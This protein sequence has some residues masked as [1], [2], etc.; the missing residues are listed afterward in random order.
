MLRLVDNKPDA[1][2]A[3]KSDA[4]VMAEALPHLR[5][6]SH[7]QALGRFGQRA[8]ESLASLAEIS[9]PSPT[10]DAS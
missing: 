3:E 7:C 2:P 8:A 4:E 10:E 9:A 6:L 5:R 1:K